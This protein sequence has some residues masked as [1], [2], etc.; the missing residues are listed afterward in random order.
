VEEVDQVRAGLKRNGLD[1]AVRHFELAEDAYARE[2]W[3]AANSQVRTYLDALFEGVANV[4]LSSSATGGA[5]RKALQDAALITD[6][7][8]EAIQKFMAYAGERGSHPGLS[9][10]EDARSRRLAGLG[11][12]I[13]GLALL[14]E[15]DRVSEVFQRT[16]T[17]PPGGQIPSE[18]G[19]RTMCPSCKESQS[20]SEA[21]ASREGEST[22]YVCKNG[23][24]RLV[25]V[26]PPGD[27]PWPG[28][29]YRLKDWTIR[30]AADL[31]FNVT[32]LGGRAVLIPASAAALKRE[33]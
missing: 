25:V 1:A 30:N 11:F 28:R 9:D 13:L 27:T 5:A 8:G 26:S 12:A 18:S 16:L 32:P 20:L 14:P 7:Q 17:A 4:R 21:T 19:I 10:H 24:Q 29:G 23:C 22:V 6:K 15:L 33:R 2:R 31:T 3:E